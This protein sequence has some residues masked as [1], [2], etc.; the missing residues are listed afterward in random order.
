M[1]EQTQKSRDEM[2]QQKQ[3]IEEEIQEIQI[4]INQL[5]NTPSGLNKEIYE[6]FRTHFFDG[7]EVEEC[8][9]PLFARVLG[10][11]RFF[12]VYISKKVNKTN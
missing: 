1:L 6:E 10:H 5:P 4:V 2:N 9:E 12:P 11:D 8:V 3:Q 7:R